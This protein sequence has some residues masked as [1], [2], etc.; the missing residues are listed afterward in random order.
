LGSG[1]FGAVFKAQCR[2][3]HEWR[4][5]KKLGPCISNGLDMMINQR[6]WGMP[7][8]APFFEDL[9]LNQAQTYVTCSY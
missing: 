4:A 6:I 5:I 2:L 7:M 8:Y 3:T 9:Y 1:A